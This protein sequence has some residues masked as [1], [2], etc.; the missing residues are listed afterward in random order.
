MS[1]VIKRLEELIEI[2]GD[3]ECFTNGEYGVE[4]MEIMTNDHIS[5]GEADLIM[6]EQYK[7]FPV[8]K[9]QVVCNIGGY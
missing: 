8:T 3:V 5:V 7:D 9:L 6:G 4:N 1:E 2:R